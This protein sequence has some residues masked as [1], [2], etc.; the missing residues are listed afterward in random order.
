[1]VGASGPGIFERNASP[2]WVHLNEAANACRLFSSNVSEVTKKGRRLTC[3]RPRVSAGIVR[4]ILIGSTVSVQRIYWTW[5][6]EV[7]CVSF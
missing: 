7:I 4:N 5:E 3:G 1:M 2:C 6:R